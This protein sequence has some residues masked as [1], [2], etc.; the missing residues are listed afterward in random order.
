MAYLYLKVDASNLSVG[1]MNRVV[2]NNPQFT[3]SS[4]SG[5][6][7]TLT[8]NTSVAHGYSNGDTV[9]V[10][11][12][13]AAS[14]APVTYTEPV[15]SLVRPIEGLFTISSAGTPGV[16]TSFQITIPAAASAAAASGAVSKFTAPAAGDMNGICNLLSG[17]QAGAIDAVV[18]VSSSNAD[19][20]LPPSSQG[21]AGVA[22]ALNCYNLK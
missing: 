21:G 5:G 9:I 3:V 12:L 13:L 20:A 19:R 8:V 18:E 16:S 10:A 2:G 15:T 4:T 17:I 6:G 7:T 1:D 22:G 11:G 14:G